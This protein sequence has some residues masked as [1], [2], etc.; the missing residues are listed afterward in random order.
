M[1]K[2]FDEKWNIKPYK[3]RCIKFFLNPTN[4][5]IKVLDDFVKNYDDGIN[6]MSSVVYSKIKEGTLS[7]DEVRR[8]RNS[9]LTG[10]LWKEY[11]SYLE[12]NFGL[13]KPRHKRGVASLALRFYRGYGARN[14]K[15]PST[16]PRIRNKNS[17][18]LED[19]TVRLVD[20][21]LNIC[22][23]GIFNDKPLSINVP[24]DVPKGM[25]YKIKYVL[26]QPGGQLI[27]K[28]DKR[29]FVARVKVPF[30][31][32]YKPKGSLGF[33]LNKTPD[34]FITLSDPINFNE[35]VCKKLPHSKLVSKLA[36]RLVALNK[37]I[38][39]KEIKSSQRRA[40][41]RKWKAV[42]RKLHKA[43]HDYCTQIINHV[44]ENQ[45][46][47]CIDNLA[48]GAKHGSFGQDKI[49]KTLIE[50]CENMRIP[51]V[52][53]PTP[54]TT[55]A[56]SKCGEKCNDRPRHDKIICP[57]CGELS[58]H[59]NGAENVRDWGYR[60]W[61]DGIEFFNKWHDEKYR[62]VEKTLG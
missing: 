15:L 1:A 61:K 48:C 33:D 51:F 12:S 28:N 53:V 35:E 30:L 2:K 46:L 16:P 8:K 4:H 26:K 42:H 11:E 62:R 21:K 59:Y 50:M 37:E 23:H 17:I 34:W 9:K 13:Y 47:L 41:R 10:K 20:D 24:Y 54:H 55:K 39:N 31:W 52:C 60:I 18:S 5:D 56:C 43:C 58:A 57:N 40:I 38:K 22:V 7:W 36:K 49:L 32:S 25:A 3:D 27:V 29:Y 14:C 44:K 19:G 45:L 6:Y